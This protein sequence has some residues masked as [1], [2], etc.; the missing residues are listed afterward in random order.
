M[1]K[2][3]TI[4]IKQ[5]ICK[6]TLFDDKNALCIKLYLHFIM[7]RACMLANKDDVCIRYVERVF[8]IT[9]RT[10]LQASIT[11]HTK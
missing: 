5:A 10:L 9:K 3:T 4:Y 7:P 6:K 8:L 2:I 1:H 11:K